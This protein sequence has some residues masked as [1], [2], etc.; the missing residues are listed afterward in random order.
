[1]R[2]TGAS[3]H[4]TKLDENDRKLIK[5][6]RFPQCCG[7]EWDL[8]KHSMTFQEISIKFEVYAQTIRSVLQREKTNANKL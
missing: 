3:H 4:R 1:M 8:C 6:L 2:K 7:G 5:Q